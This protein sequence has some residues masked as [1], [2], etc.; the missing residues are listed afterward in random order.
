MKISAS[1]LA[2]YSRFPTKPE[3][4]PSGR[5]RPVGAAPAND[6]FTPS[7][8]L[9]RATAVMFRAINEELA[10]MAEGYGFDPQPFLIPMV[11]SEH[12]AGARMANMTEALFDLYALQHDGL[13]RETLLDS[14]QRD[15][16]GVIDRG[17]AR[18]LQ[19]LEAV[20]ADRAHG[21]LAKTVVSAHHRIT[22]YLAELRAE[23]KAED[24][25]RSPVPVTVPT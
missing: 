19:L 6:W 12:A 21:E 13:D 16:V 25:E 2:A 22:D 3:Q 10:A 1:G 17:Y 20:G 7:P 23:T 5:G 11:Q 8:E 4:T 14:F 18:S 15:V 9:A 24:G